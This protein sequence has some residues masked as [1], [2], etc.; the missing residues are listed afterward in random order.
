MSAL[1]LTLQFSFMYGFP[2]SWS[3]LIQNSYFA[4]QMSQ[5]QLDGLHEVCLSQALI[6]GESIQFCPNLTGICS[7]LPCKRRRQLPVHG[8]LRHRHPCSRRGL[9]SDCEQTIT[10][11]LHSRSSASDALTMIRPS[12]V[13]KASIYDQAS[14]RFLSLAQREDEHLHSYCFVLCS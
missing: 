7:S 2:G 14:G 3:A 9:R 5:D 1:L 8:L 6:Y 10:P 11:C 13:T 4:Q 12:P